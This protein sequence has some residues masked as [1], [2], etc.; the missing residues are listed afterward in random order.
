M[1]NPTQ[2]AVLLLQA[3]GRLFVKAKA[4]AAG[5]AV[6]FCQQAG[7]STVRSRWMIPGH[8]RTYV[9][10]R[11]PEHVRSLEVKGAS[12]LDTQPRMQTTILKYW[13]KCACHQ[14]NPVA[15]FKEQRRPTRNKLA[16]HSTA[17]LPSDNT[18]ARAN[19]R[20]REPARQD[21]PPPPKKKGAYPKTRGLLILK[22]PCMRRDFGIPKTKDHT[23]T[24]TVWW[25]PLDKRNGDHPP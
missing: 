13:S 16:Q 4:T 9:S 17:H 11:I 14:K 24:E 19:R 8:V 5:G 3:N 25:G 12:N 1:G 15:A 2:R 7:I 20:D 10:R 21:T 6:P 18:R 23:K 22:T